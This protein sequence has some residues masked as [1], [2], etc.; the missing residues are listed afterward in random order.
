MFATITLM[1][2]ALI[3]F[4]IA[5]I[6]VLKSADWF[7]DAVGKIGTYFR[8][9]AF[10]MGVALVGFG[11]SLPELAT[12]L[13]AVAAGNADIALPNVIGSNIAN[14][15]LILGISAL[16]FQSIRIRDD[17]ARIDIPILLCATAV[18]IALVATGGLSTFDAA[19]LLVGFFLYLGYTLFFKENPAAR[20]GLGAAILTTFA[21]KTSPAKGSPKPGLGSYALLLGS[22]LL[23]GIGSQMVIASLNT[24]VDELAIS[25]GI[26]SFFA[27]AIGTSLPE[28]VVSLKALKKGEG[29]L[30]IGNIIGSSMFNMLLIGG[31][32]G[33]LAPQVL[34]EGAAGWMLGG[35]AI[36]TIPLLF[37]GIAGRVGRR[38]GLVFVALYA[39]I[40]VV[41]L[42]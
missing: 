12:S 42:S 7:L 21:R 32:A 26:L 25:A 41:L 23:L 36:A 9:P 35:L 19:L 22:I 27:L 24:I 34:P 16:V 13:A 17:I 18:F 30:V 4:V 31:V 29:D 39:V 6:A 15:L 33:L 3:L 38:P 28:L 8:I 40:S 10:L 2:L 1:W 11:T 14:T 37:A 5:L 20:K